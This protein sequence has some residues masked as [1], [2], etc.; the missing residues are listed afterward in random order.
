MYGAEMLRPGAAGE[1]TGKQAREKRKREK[2]SLKKWLWET[3][4]WCLC[5]FLFSLAQ[6]LSVPSPYAV[7]CL[8]AALACR[9]TI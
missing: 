1:K 6:C 4:P 2:I 9:R 3:L 8:M 7:C 5:F